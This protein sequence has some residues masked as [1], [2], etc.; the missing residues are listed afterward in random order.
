M[1]LV[2]ALG[3]QVRVAARLPLRGDRLLQLLLCRVGDALLG[4]AADNCRFQRLA[5]ETRPLH[6]PQRQT[7]DEAAPLRQDLDQPVLDQAERRP[8]QAPGGRRS[9][10]QVRSRTAVPPAA[11]AGSRS[12]AAA[13]RRSGADPDRRQPCRSV[14][15]ACRRGGARAAPHRKPIDIHGMSVIRI[16]A[17]NKAAR[18]GQTERMAT[19]GDTRPIAQ[20]RWKPTPKGGV[21]SPKPMANTATMA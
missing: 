2:V 16:R 1:E 13:R 5:H 12:R 18:C 19:S 21:N 11:A 6:R 10:L 15:S 14:W 3:E 17:T 9:G 4:R 8:A 7:A 20:A